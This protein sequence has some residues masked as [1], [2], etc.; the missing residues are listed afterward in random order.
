MVCVVLCVCRTCDLSHCSPYLLIP[1]LRAPSLVI[2]FHPSL[3]TNVYLLPSNLIICVLHLSACLRLPS[4]PCQ[5]SHP[6]RVVTRSV[7]PLPPSHVPSQ[8]R[9][10][11]ERV[12]FPLLLAPLP[13]HLEPTPSIFLLGNNLQD[14]LSPPFS[15]TKTKNTNNSVA[16]RRSPFQHAKRTAS[17]LPV[18]KLD[19]PLVPSPP[20]PLCV[21]CLRTRPLTLHLLPVPFPPHPATHPPPAPASLLPS[22][23]PTLT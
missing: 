14:S 18:H 9:P 5:S 4:V 3:P 8:I 16:C 10:S 19:S 21:L 22:L 15:K 6:S 1:G 7:V 13:L 11:F 2:I 17:S 12:L 23:T 20:R